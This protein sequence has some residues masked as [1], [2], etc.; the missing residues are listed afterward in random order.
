MFLVLYLLTT[1]FVR[2][3]GAAVFNGTGIFVYSYKLTYIN[4][5]IQVAY[6]PENL[7]KCE[8]SSVFRSCGWEPVLV[9]LMPGKIKA[10]IELG[11]F[12]NIYIYIYSYNWNT[13]FPWKYDSAV[14]KWMP[15]RRDHSQVVHSRMVIHV[16]RVWMNG[17]VYGYCF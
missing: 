5:G 11:L 8:Y 16:Y 13:T 10:L 4:S 17:L 12:L 2:S 6:R 1:L 3:S 9:S 7:Y 15:L 14:K